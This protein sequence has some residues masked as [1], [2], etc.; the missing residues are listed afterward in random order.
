MGK[1]LQAR[2]KRRIEVVFLAIA[3]LMIGTLSPAGAVR[4]EENNLAALRDDVR[5]DGASGGGSDDDSTKPRRPYHDKEEEDPADSSLG[6]MLAD[7]GAIVALSPFWLPRTAVDDT[8]GDGYFSRWPYRDGPH[9]MTIDRW[10][11]GSRRWSARLRGDYAEDFDD[12]SR[13]SGHLLV[14]TSARFGLDTEMNFLQERLP[15]RRRDELW[16]GDCNLVY[17]FAQS[18]RSQWR[19]GLGFNWLDDAADTNFG[20]NFTY[21]FDLYPV[22]PLVL[23]TELDWG[24]LGSAEAFHFRTTAG[25]VLFG[26]ESYVGYEYRDIDRFHFNGLVAGVRVWF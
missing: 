25:V 4:A 12:M 13:I 19:A 8:G 15:E 10:T 20:F 11:D 2:E 7:M 23:S 3:G 1:V 9:Y 24:T 21:G 14:S 6:R 16:L 26:L 17:R 22:K 5:S 18:E